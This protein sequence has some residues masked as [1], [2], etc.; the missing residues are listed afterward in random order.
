MTLDYATKTLADAEGKRDAARKRM[1]DA[2]EGS[3]AWH[4]AADDLNFWQGK[5]ANM[6][7]AISSGIAT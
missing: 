1:N 2:K 4:D 7:A 5:V 3:R 6:D